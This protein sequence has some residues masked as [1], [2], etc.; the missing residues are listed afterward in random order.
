MADIKQA[1][2]WMKEG[3]SVRRSAWPIG[4][5]AVYVG[6]LTPTQ[7]MYVITKPMAFTNNIP[8]TADYGIKLDSLLAEDWEVC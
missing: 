2:E 1:A 6:E 4:N 3:K 5:I 8:T 7:M